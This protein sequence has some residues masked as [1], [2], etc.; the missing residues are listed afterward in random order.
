MCFGSKTLC[1]IGELQGMCLLF[2]RSMC[3]QDQSEHMAL[4]SMAAMI[5]FSMLTEVA[6]QLVEVV[7]GVA[8]ALTCYKS[9]CH[10]SAD[11]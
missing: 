4:A 11:P 9:H 6:T 7:S 2:A 5:G 8:N 3:L 1:Y 10:S